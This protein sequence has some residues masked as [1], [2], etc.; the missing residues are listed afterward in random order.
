M[1]LGKAL[2]TTRQRHSVAAAA[3]LA[4]VA[5]LLQF[6]GEDA[7]R[8][9]AWDREAL[10][11]GESWRLVSGHFVHLGWSHLVLNL[12]G[13]GLVAWITGAAYGLLRWAVI[14]V[15]TIAVID[16][17][18]WYLYPDLDWYVGLSGV[19]HGLLAA[20]LL[21]GVRQRDREAIVLAV[22]VAGKLLWEQTVGPL[23]GSESGAGGS[24]IVNAHLY[25]AVGGLL[26]ALLSWHRVRP[27][28]SI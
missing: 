13:L 24:V 5:I 9:L 16:A 26:G 7:R 22:L 10:A 20:G 28:A 21:A 15:T 27:E 17:G 23:P 14:A 2:N 4:A 11:A 8:I 25:G 12:A 3:T 6:G 1:G 18:F 19:L